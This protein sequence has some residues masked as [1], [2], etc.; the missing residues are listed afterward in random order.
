VHD[1]THDSGCED[2]VLHVGVPTCPETLKDVQVNIVLGQ[3]I[4]DTKVGIW[5]CQ[6]GIGNKRHGCDREGKEMVVKASC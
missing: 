1:E 3:L 2:I 4:V 5:S 6:G